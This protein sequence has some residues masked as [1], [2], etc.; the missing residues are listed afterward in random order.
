MSLL[1]KAVSDWSK[2]ICYSAYTL[3][4]KWVVVWPTCSSDKHMGC[5]TKVDTPLAPTYESM[6]K[7]QSDNTGSE[8]QIKRQQIYRKNS[9]PWRCWHCPRSRDSN[10]AVR[11]IQWKQ[12]LGHKWEDD[13]DKQV[14]MSCRKWHWQKKRSLH[15]K[16][17]LRDISHPCR[18]KR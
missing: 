10:C 5:F 15:V 12:T 9:Q 8:I 1:S 16:G 2:H 7:K 18:C 4:A 14:N 3:T 17:T 11:K 13:W 6:I